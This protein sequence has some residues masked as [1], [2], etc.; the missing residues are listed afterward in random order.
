[1]E[2]STVS[3]YNKCWFENHRVKAVL[4]VGAFL[5]LS[6]IIFCSYCSHARTHLCDVMKWGMERGKERFHVW[7][8]PAS[9]FSFSFSFS[10]A[11]KFSITESLAEQRSAW[12]PAKSPQVTCPTAHSIHHFRT[13]VG[14]FED[15]EM[16]FC[17]GMKTWLDGRSGWGEPV[18]Y[19]FCGE[20]KVYLRTCTSGRGSR[21]TS[22]G[23]TLV[24]DGSTLGSLTWKLGT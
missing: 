3:Y 21:L 6:T 20:Q 24:L 4:G 2:L 22:P 18:N 5:S 16:N 15:K 14:R 11:L 12:K 17:Q 1:M 10:L 8:V 9:S 7:N 19:L 23:T 13:Q